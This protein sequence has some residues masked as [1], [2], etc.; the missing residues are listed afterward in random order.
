V[1]EMS[2]AEQEGSK[3]VSSSLICEIVQNG[4][5][6]NVSWNDITLIKAVA[7]HSINTFNDN[8]MFHFRNIL[9]RRQKQTT[10]DNIFVRQRPSE[11]QAEKSGAKR[12]KKKKEKK[13]KPQEDGYLMFLWK[14]NHFPNNN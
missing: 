3:D 4:V 12:Q 9:K 10:L 5:M 13:K 8:A 1:E 14:R 6:C 7:S 11:S 2:S